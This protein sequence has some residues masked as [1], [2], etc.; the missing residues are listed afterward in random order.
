[1]LDHL[2]VPQA[3]VGGTSLGANV[4]LEAAVLAPERVRGLVLEMPVL[5]NALPQGMTRARRSRLQA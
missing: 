1:L 4:A 3:V 5:E 2:G